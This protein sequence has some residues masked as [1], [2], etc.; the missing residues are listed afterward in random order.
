M[1]ILDSNTIPSG[2]ASAVTTSFANKYTASSTSSGTA[3]TLDVT[4][5]ETLSGALTASTFK[6]M[7]NITG[8]SGKVPI[9]AV[10]TKDATARVI[11]LRITLDGSYVTTITSSSISSSG[12]AIIAAGTT[13]SSTVLIDGEPL[14]FKTSCLI[15]ISSSLTETDKISLVY[16]R[17][18]ES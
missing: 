3:I 8:T 15:E 7:V 5:L 18:S 4:A 11:S 14:R 12:Y 16:K 9:C 2:V 13:A 10:V 6:I 17:F 1:T